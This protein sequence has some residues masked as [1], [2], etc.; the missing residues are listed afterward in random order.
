MSNDCSSFIL[1]QHLLLEPFSYSFF[2]YLS[3]HPNNRPLRSFL[4]REIASE[5]LSAVVEAPTILRVG[6]R[7]PSACQR[8]FRLLILHT[9]RCHNCQGSRLVNIKISIASS[10]TCQILST[11]EKSSLA[12]RLNLN[13]PRYSNAYP[14]ELYD[15]A[16]TKHS[17]IWAALRPLA[18]PHSTTPIQHEIYL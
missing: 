5:A 18:Q 8:T 15:R 6:E 7:K 2:T 17:K 16:S 9:W 4:I 3:N 1:S 11:T 13:W 10:R 12:H 14:L